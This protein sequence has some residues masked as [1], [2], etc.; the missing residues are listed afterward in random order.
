MRL[1]IPAKFRLLLL[2]AVSTG[3]SHAQTQIDWFSAQN[4]RNVT[5]DGVT[6]MDGGF[7][8]ELGVFATGFTPTSA[9]IAEW[10]GILVCGVE[11]G[12]RF[13]GRAGS[14][15]RRI[16]DLRASLAGAEGFIKNK[17]RVF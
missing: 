10:Q 5:S 8:F 16:G 9:N 6:L 15:K 7:L 12:G 4:A 1:S 13:K 17:V 11:A 3:L 14:I 2:I